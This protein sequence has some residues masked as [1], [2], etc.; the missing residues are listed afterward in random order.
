MN[1]KDEVNAMPQDAELEKLRA[2]IKKLE[3][4]VEKERSRRE[5]LE[6]I[7]AMMPG[8]VYWL[9]KNN[10]YLGCNDLQAQCVGLKSWRDVVGKT[11]SDLL[12]R[13][14]EAMMVDEINNSVME[15]G[16]KCVIEEEVLVAQGVRTY[17]SQKVPLKNRRGEIMGILGISFDITDRKELE[18]LRLDVRQ[19]AITKAAEF[20]SM[21]ASSLSHDLRSPLTAMNLQMDLLKSTAAK[22]SLAQEK[23]FLDDVVKIVKGAIKS[24]S[25][26]VDDVS[27]KMKNLSCGELAGSD[28]QKFSMVRVINEVLSSY[29]F[30][31]CEK[32]LVKFDVSNDFDFMGNENLTRHL[33]FSLIKNSLRAIKEAGKGEISISLRSDDEFNYLIFRDTALGIP[34]NFI[35]KIF[36]H[37]EVNEEIKNLD[38]GAGVGL[39]FCKTVMESYGG[40]ITCN[41]E[42]GEYA[43]FILIF[44]KTSVSI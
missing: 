5:L 41:S 29:S 22:E 25:Q 34:T 11:N 1:N 8:H 19:M 21:V 35:G 6:D 28:F 17:W 7:I 14:E 38:N 23:V 33:L 4:L 16:K 44:P 9:D 42:Y 10:V 30:L 2:E 12:E 40:S 20:I 31:Q 26:V 32:G 24:V 18:K 13:K 39:A 3:A 37:F 27:A 15:S 36:D 43:E